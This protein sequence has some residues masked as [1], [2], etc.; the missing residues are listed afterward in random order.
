MQSFLNNGS[1]ADTSVAW[2]DARFG[3]AVITPTCPPDF[4]GDGTLDPDDLADYI[5]AF[6][7]QPAPISA[8]YNGDGLVDPDD[9]ADYISG[10]FA[11]C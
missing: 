4:N 1:P 3:P 2:D 6:F 10:Y 11:G 9:L 5:S 8:D 7:S